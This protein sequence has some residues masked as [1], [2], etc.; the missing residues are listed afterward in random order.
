M[1]STFATGQVEWDAFEWMH[2][3]C[4]PNLIQLACFLP[5]NDDKLRN[6]ISKYACLPYDFLKNCFFLLSVSQWFGD[7]YTTCVM[8][9]LFLIAVGDDSDLTHFPS[10]VHSRIKGNGDF[11]QIL[12]GIFA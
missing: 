8:L 7:S 9:P 4:F 6:R 5:Q 2:V 3:E 1:V 10:A 11:I 12:C